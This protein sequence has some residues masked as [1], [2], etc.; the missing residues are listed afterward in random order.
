MLGGE[1]V[2]NENEL[3]EPLATEAGQQAIARAINNLGSLEN[4]VRA[5]RAAATA[6]QK[7][8][9]ARNSAE[10]A[11]DYATEARNWANK[12]D[13]YVAQETITIPPEQEGDEPT[14][15]T[16]DLYSAKYYAAL[17]QD[18]YN[19]LQF[20]TEPT[21]DSTKLLSSGAIY[22]ALNGKADK[23]DTY[24]KTEVDTALSNVQSTLTF[25]STPTAN[26]NNPVTSDGIYTALQ[27]VEIDID[28]EITEDSDNP[29]TSAAIYEALQNIEVTGG[30]GN[31]SGVTQEVLY[32][33]TWTSGSITLS[34]PITDFDFIAVYYTG[35]DWGNS[36]EKNSVYQVYPTKPIIENIGYM[37]NYYG[38]D[39]YRCCIIANSATQFTID[40]VA[41]Y[42][43]YKIVGIK[44]SKNLS[45]QM[46]SNVLYEN[47]SGWSSGSITLNDDFTNYDF[48]EFVY[49]EQN[50]Q[51]QRYSKVIPSERLR[52]TEQ[53]NKQFVIDGVDNQYILFSIQS[54]S[55]TIISRINYQ[56]YEIIG[57]KL[58]KGGY[59]GIV[60]DARMTVK[61]GTIDVGAISGA[62]NKA[63]PVIF[64]SPMPDTNYH[65]FVCK[66]AKSTY[67]ERIFETASESSKTVNGFN[68]DCWISGDVASGCKINWIA[69]RPNSYTREGMVEDVL[70]NT[71]TPVYTQG[72]VINLSGNISDYDLIEI[73]TRFTAN[74]GGEPWKYHV[75]NIFSS[76]ELL[77]TQ[78]QD[79]KNLNN[80]YSNGYITSYCANGDNQ[81][82]C[83][84]NV[85]QM[86]ITKVVGIKFGRYVSG[87]AVDTTVTQ[88]SNAVVTSGAVY[89]ALQNIP[90]GGGGG[91]SITLD[92]IPIEN[93]T[94]GI[95]S[96]AVW[97]ALVNRFAP[98]FSG[99]IPNDMKV[100]NADQLLFQNGSSNNYYKKYNGIAAGA[101]VILPDNF[102]SA[103]LVSTNENNVIQYSS[104]N[105]SVAHTIIYDNKTFYYS[106][107]VNTLRTNMN[108][109][110]F[111][112]R[113]TSTWFASEEAA[114]RY[115]LD[116]VLSAPSR[117]LANYNIT[118]AYTKTEVD[119]LLQNAGGSSIT[120]DSTITQGGTNP[121]EGG[122]IYTALGD[123]A[124]QSTTYTKTEVDTALA[125]K[126]DVTTDTAQNITGTKTF[127]GSKKVAFKQSAANDKLGFTLF[128]N[129]GTER[130]YL[131]FNPTNTVDGVA[132]LMTLGNYATSAAGLTQV[133][134]RRYSNISGA[135]GAYNLLMP[136]VADARTP[137][138]L[139]TSYQ[140]FYLPLGFTNGTTTVKT[141]KSGLVD[142]S[143]LLA[144]LE[145]RIAAL[146]GN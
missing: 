21:E 32:Q 19:N 72:E 30:V 40:T 123:K 136:M 134:F 101:V 130:G 133:G 110:N 24:T 28:G 119:T 29:V 112:I 94:N 64:D 106:G 2:S 65:V 12:T 99:D 58:A 14:T 50:I 71:D 46:Y 80:T 145:A 114:A 132:G 43:A 121:V 115:I 76:Q 116:Q 89:D 49:G 33:G 47:A 143:P 146:E 67:Y 59:S 118:N 73:T 74:S 25:D 79:K 35:T 52:E 113:W 107:S 77:D 140:N 98:D 124:D 68:I 126:G 131:E 100:E 27:N 97:N 103:I 138:S 48:I 31:A 56:L 8:D 5:E 36:K 141:A 37:F 81:I 20:D 96:G 86:G 87:V 135:S 17:A 13:G 142:L 15:E 9:E 38:Y 109:R 127:V 82:I 128:G 60:S 45:E 144:S 66:S 70:F 34:K 62:Q 7:A 88:N 129:T 120:V 55:F 23:S 84:G 41:N 95:T 39:T 57:I 16:I 44:F 18:I 61:S 63:F 111:S 75:K 102:V 91:G 53:D 69:I 104:N 1:G 93:S 92:S 6:T 54:N 4:A 3:L 83:R 85:G 22:T 108:P 137:F 90:S 51:N 10:D 117:T 122:A 139:T 11:S 26:S 105:Q 42:Y 78:N 125:S